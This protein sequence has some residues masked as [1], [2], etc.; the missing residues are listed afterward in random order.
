M[1]CAKCGRNNSPAN[2]FCAKCGNALAKQRTKCQA[3]NPPTSDFCG[4]C[5]AA[6]GAFGNAWI[7]GQNSHSLSRHY[8]PSL[9]DA[10]AWVTGVHFKWREDS[11]WFPWTFIERWR[12]LGATVS[13]H[14]RC[15]FY[16]SKKH[17][18]VA[19]FC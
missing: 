4:N 1:R 13:N 8:P 18:T 6:L 17:W 15:I 10:V 2:D 14:S 7:M 5:G 11:A 12:E 16:W 3:E 9:R 19:Q